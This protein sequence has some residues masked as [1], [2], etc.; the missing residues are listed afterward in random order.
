MYNSAAVPFDDRRELIFPTGFGM[1][2]FIGG[3]QDQT[4]TLNAYVVDGNLVN[5]VE[6]N[7]SSVIEADDKWITF[8]P[9]MITIGDDQYL[10]YQTRDFEHDTSPTFGVNVSRY[11]IVPV[12]IDRE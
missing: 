2:S 10:V 12:V 6:T 4:Y 8:A 5:E 3:V 9:S 7:I 11:R 1:N